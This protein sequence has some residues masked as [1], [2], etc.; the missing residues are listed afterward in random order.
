MLKL[1]HSHLFA[2]G[3]LSSKFREFCRRYGVFFSVRPR[4]SIRRGTTA[5]AA[6]GRVFASI[7]LRLVEQLEKLR[8]Q[9][10]MANGTV[11]ACSMPLVDTVAEMID[12]HAACK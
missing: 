6:D 4:R 12:K 9:Q 5:A 10:H 2:A 3:N 11:L 1:K 8:W 7:F